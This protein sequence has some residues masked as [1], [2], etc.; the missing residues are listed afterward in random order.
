MCCLRLVAGMSTAG[1]SMRLAFRRR[2]NMSAMGSVIMAVLS[3]PARLFDA[4]D[5]PVAR[6]VPET[7]AANGELAVDRPRPAAQAAAQPNA[8]L[9]ARP[10]LGLGRVALV[11][12]QLG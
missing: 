9:V 2:V 11:A 10:E 6:H 7:D 8:N 12:L 4:G 1:R 3:S 5:E